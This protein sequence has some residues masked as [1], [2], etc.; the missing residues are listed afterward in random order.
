MIITTADYMK[1]KKILF[2]KNA[3]IY[4]IDKEKKLLKVPQVI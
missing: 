3:E 1:I 2:A 4:I